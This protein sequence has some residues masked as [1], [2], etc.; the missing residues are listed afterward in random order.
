MR[1]LLDRC[2]QIP[3]VRGGEGAEMMAA[4]EDEMNDLNERVTVYLQLHAPNWV[5]YFKGMP[6]GHSSW[7]VTLMEDRR[8]QLIELGEFSV[9]QLEHIARMTETDLY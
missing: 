3:S 5:R 2:K 7:V 4:V 9:D 6:D 8:K 1:T